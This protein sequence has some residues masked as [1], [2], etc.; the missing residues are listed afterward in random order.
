[1]NL[2]HQKKGIKL[3]QTTFYQLLGYK[4]PT[5]LTTYKQILVK[6]GILPSSS[7]GNYGYQMG[8]HA[9]RYTLTKWATGVMNNRGTEATTIAS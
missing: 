1:V 4:N 2:L 5:R 7:V 3:S 9:K 8:H 6:A